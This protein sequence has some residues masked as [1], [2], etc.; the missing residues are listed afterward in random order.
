MEVERVD[1]CKSSNSFLAQLPGLGGLISQAPTGRAL[2][3]LNH[4]G[5]ISPAACVTFQLFFEIDRQPNVSP[6][7]VVAPSLHL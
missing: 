3:A 6:N 2:S 7:W 4:I 5:R 1:P